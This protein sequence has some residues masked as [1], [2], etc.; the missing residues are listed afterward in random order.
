VGSTLRIGHNFL[1]SGPG[2]ASLIT[3]KPLNANQGNTGTQAG[4]KST[5]LHWAP[6]SFRLALGLPHWSK[7]PTLKPLSGCQPKETQATQAGQWETHCVSTGFPSRLA[8]GSAW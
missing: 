1:L 5:H 8:L 2:S 7:R 4:D 6:A 3:L